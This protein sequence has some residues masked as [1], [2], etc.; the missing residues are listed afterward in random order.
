[1]NVLGDAFIGKYKGEGTI[2]Q[3]API[4]PD[5]ITVEVSGQRVIYILDGRTEH[6]P[7]DI[8]HIKR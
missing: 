8:L 3:L 4:H 1:L 5:R 6:G 7:D 2:V